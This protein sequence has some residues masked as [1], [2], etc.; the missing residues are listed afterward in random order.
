MKIKFFKSSFLLNKA[1]KLVLRGYL[2]DGKPFGYNNTIFCIESISKKFYSIKSD[3]NELIKNKD[4]EN[5][6][7]NNKNHQKEKLLKITLK[8]KLIMNSHIKNQNKII[9]NY[10]N[11]KPQ[12][13]IKNNV[14]ENDNLNKTKNLDTSNINQNQKKNIKYKKEDIKNKDLYNKIGQ[15][16]ELVKRTN[17]ENLKSEITLKN[18]NLTPIELNNSI[19]KVISERKHQAKEFIMSLIA[20]NEEENGINEVMEDPILNRNFKLLIKILIDDFDLFNKLRISLIFLKFKKQHESL[21]SSLLEGIIQELNSF[22]ELNMEEKSKEKIIEKFLLIEKTF[23]IINKHNIDREKIDFEK[24]NLLISALE[25]N[26]NFFEIIFKNNQN[27]FFSFFNEFTRFENETLKI[28]DEIIARTN[29]VYFKLTNFTLKNFNLF[30]MESLMKMLDYINKNNHRD[31]QFLKYIFLYFIKHIRENPQSLKNEKFKGILIYLN[32]ILIN[33]NV[34]FDTRYSELDDFQKF[35]YLE[36]NEISEEMGDFYKDRKANV[37]N[38]IKN[39]VENSNEIKDKN[40]IEISKAEVNK[41][42]YPHL[43]VNDYENSLFF[44]NVILKIYLEN[45]KNTI[46]KNSQI[47]YNLKVLCFIHDGLL[48]NFFLDGKLK[49]D[50]SNYILLSKNL[51]QEKYGNDENYKNEIKNN[52]SLYNFLSTENKILK[53]LKNEDNKNLILKILNVLQDIIKKT[54]DSANFKNDMKKFY[55]IS[56]TEINYFDNK[57]KLEEIKYLGNVIIS[58][59]YLRSINNI[60]QFDENIFIN[61]FS[62]DKSLFE[63]SIITNFHKEI[64]RLLIQLNIKFN[65]EGKIDDIDKDIEVVYYDKKLKICI[66]LDGY[67]HFYRDNVMNFKTIF[68]RKILQRLGWKIISFKY[69]DWMKIK[70]EEEKLYILKRK[71]DYLIKEKDK[72]F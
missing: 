52:L 47:F 43:L 21:F 1:N 50:T 66:E 35:N 61:F 25:K 37:L 67:Y 29:I 42:F 60:I 26:F 70:D 58:I 38:K 30:N 31:T 57:E 44:F 69:S 49:S 39:K 64:I 62:I 22:S 59:N 12:N 32:F 5:K 40:E 72:I 10:T 20:N 11:N 18:K 14:D 55:E 63:K 3:K 13:T 15:N 65:V 34:F 2:G 17:L 27:E 48:K 53:I 36:G 24:V 16:I 19:E 8:E 33:N 68:K 23:K 54:L 45:L 9:T 41:Y 51:Y 6:K 7:Y 4:F 28:K 71:I 56:K 46:N